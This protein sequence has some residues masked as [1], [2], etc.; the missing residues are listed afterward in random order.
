MKQNNLINVNHIK[1]KTMRKY[2][3]YNA[4][5]FNS[6]DEFIKH[7]KNDLIVYPDGIS[8]DNDLYNYALIN[9]YVQVKIIQILPY[10]KIRL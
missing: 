8:D 1:H 9:D 7:F 10:K 2:Y 5:V 4:I 6:K 3:I